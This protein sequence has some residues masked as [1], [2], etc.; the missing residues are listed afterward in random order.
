MVTG[1][2]HKEKPIS[3]IDR[4]LICPSMFLCRGSVPC[5]EVVRRF[6]VVTSIARLKRKTRAGK[7][8]GWGVSRKKEEEEEEGGA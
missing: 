5:P 3:L 8:E 2:K 1:W 4:R 7:E 6:G